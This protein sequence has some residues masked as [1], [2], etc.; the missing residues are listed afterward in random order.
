MLRE[1]IKQGIPLPV[2]RPDTR[3]T[4]PEKT[5]IIDCIH[6]SQCDY[7]RFFFTTVPVGESPTV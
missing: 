2:R 1:P 7:S 6:A 3:L 4:I 5:P